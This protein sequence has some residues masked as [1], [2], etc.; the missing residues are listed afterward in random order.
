MAQ[1]SISFCPDLKSDTPPSIY[2]GEAFRLGDGRNCGTCST[3]TCDIPIK[4]PIG[5]YT[6]GYYLHRNRD[7]NRL[8]F[9]YEI[10]NNPETLKATLELEAESQK[11]KLQDKKN[12]PQVITVPTNPHLRKIADE[13][14]A[15]M[16]ESYDKFQAY[17]KI[18]NPWGE[19]AFLF[20]SL[21]VRDGFLTLSVTFEGRQASMYDYAIHGLA[22][23][24]LQN[25]TPLVVNDSVIQGS[26]NSEYPSFE[27]KVN[28]SR[29]SISWT[30]YPPKRRTPPDL[31]FSYGTLKNGK[32][33]VDTLLTYKLQNGKSAYVVGLTDE[34][35]IKRFSFDAVDR[36][37]LAGDTS[38]CVIEAS[39]EMN[40]KTVMLE[41][42]DV[43]GN[44]IS[45]KVMLLEYEQERPIFQLYDT[46]TK[47][48][49]T[50]GD[51]RELAKHN[52]RFQLLGRVT[53]ASPLRSIKV[54]GKPV[55]WDE[56][57]EFIVGLLPSDNGR[58][59]RVEVVDIHGNKNVPC[60]FNIIFKES[61]A[62]RTMKL[63]HEE[64]FSSRNE[65]YLKKNGI[66]GLTLEIKNDK[67]YLQKTPVEDTIQSAAAA[68]EDVVVQQKRSTLGQSVGFG[69]PMLDFNSDFELQIAYSTLL[70]KSQYFLTFGMDDSWESYYYVFG[71]GDNLF[72]G[73]V[74]NKLYMCRGEG[75]DNQRFRTTYST[76][77][78]LSRTHV[79]PGFFEKGR[80]VEYILTIKRYNEF[81]W[82]SK[83]DPKDWLVIEIKNGIDPPA[84]LKFPLTESNA[85]IVGTRCG[86]ALWDNTAMAISKIT[87]KKGQQDLVPA[88]YPDSE[89]EKYCFPV[90][91]NLDSAEKKDF[92][93]C[94]TTSYQALIVANGDFGGRISALP[95]SVETGNELKNMLI[96][97]YQ[98][99]ADQVK[100]LENA[101]RDQFMG[102]LEKSLPATTSKDT[103]LVI[104]VISHGT[105]DKTIEF[106]DAP[107]QSEDIWNR[108]NKKKADGSY[109]I[110]CKQILF[111]I[112]ACFSGEMTPTKQQ[113]Y[114]PSR[115]VCDATNRSS[116][117]VLTS[118][119]SNP[120]KESLLTKELVKHLRLNSTRY[121]TIDKLFD[122]AKKDFLKEMSGNTEPT[123]T[124]F[125]QTNHESKGSFLFIKRKFFQ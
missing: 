125:E 26:I 58:E 17:T 19:L 83:D 80:G 79:N 60:K 35:K 2:S 63:V 30:C 9:V 90:C 99:P 85:R 109:A 36:E 11:H 87:F 54:N 40:M 88:F 27:I 78:Y 92:F 7:N 10:G 39:P 28:H 57:K 45:K 102:Y 68:D 29:K 48:Y 18:E 47:Q 82:G 106:K 94:L 81:Y 93:D 1:I 124:I 105:Q 108:L 34:S 6:L 119:S 118:A 113:E 96:N 86:A 44:L 120:T 4:D 73:Q 20:E 14:R 41:A 3:A 112:D 77:P 97:D 50:P 110:E 91:Y 69:L 74:D 43:H 49:L 103:R 116:R 66:A 75:C 15:I 98:F 52:Q 65:G 70:E 115:S 61:E 104:W 25:G 51:E 62:D 55:N 24:I 101:T 84:T 117:L 56:K 37:L 22:Q 107:V 33:G 76:F 122:L 123:L 59:M 64:E 46:R 72:L 53:D 5:G 67:F 38:L 21:T 71:E 89:I 13:L 32:T 23:D 42:E 12:G 111:V 100:I 95:S 114:D 31:I 16:K 121:M 8:E